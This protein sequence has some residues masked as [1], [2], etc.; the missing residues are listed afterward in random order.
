MAEA[1]ENPD[2]HVYDMD[3]TL[4]LTPEPGTH[5]S[6]YQKLTGKPFGKGWWSRHESLRPPLEA[7]PIPDVI[8][9]YHQAKEDGHHVV[10]MTGRVDKPEMR[11]AVSDTL[12]KLGLAGHVHGRDLFL[13]PDDEDVE[14]EDWK[15][16]KLFDLVK[17][18]KPAHVHI[19]DDRK[20]HGVA[21]AHM[22]KSLGVPHTFHYVQHP[23]WGSA[24]T[25]PKTS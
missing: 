20:A 4:A 15:K 25:M 17:Q 2:L 9:R 5:K 13:K 1:S 7:E 14:T 11:D 6:L 8:D 18:H 22:L 16:S 12:G 24:K 19:Y 3:G 23:G 10:V 21:F